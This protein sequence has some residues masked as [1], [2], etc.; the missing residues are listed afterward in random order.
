MK[1]RIPFKMFGKE[2]GEIVI[3]YPASAN[4]MVDMS[5]ESIEARARE[6]AE[7][8]GRYLGAFR[9]KFQKIILGY[10]RVP[11]IESVY[12]TLRLCSEDGIL[13]E[14]LLE[15]ARERHEEAIRLKDEE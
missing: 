13:R 14:R 7:E 1:I 4:Y 10:E 5:K 8:V 2:D 11:G 12:E 15:L 9:D 3:D 6:D